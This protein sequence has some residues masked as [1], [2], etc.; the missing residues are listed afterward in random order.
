[1]TQRRGAMFDLPPSPLPQGETGRPVSSTQIVNAFWQF[2]P[3]KSTTFYSRV[4]FR[5]Y[6]RPLFI[7]LA[8]P[9]PAT[10]PVAA[11]TVP[12]NQSLIIKEIEFTA[13]QSTGVGSISAIPAADV[14]SYLAFSTKIGNRSPFDFQTNTAIR[15]APVNYQ[16]ANSTILFTTPLPSQ[17][18]SSPFSGPQQ[19]VGENFASYAVAGETI[20]LVAYV[21]REPPFDV[22]MI[23]AKIAGYNLNQNLLQSILARIT[24]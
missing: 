9:Y 1:M 17:S 4:Y 16:N 7:G 23:S 11:I 3:S 19:P 8:Q 2:L 21:L 24:A 18:T 13:F 6:P 12:K 22:S 20:E 5:E 14:A 15:N 10:I